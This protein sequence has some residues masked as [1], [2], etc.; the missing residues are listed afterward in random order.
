MRSFAG[1]A[2]QRSGRTPRDLGRLRKEGRQ[3][4]IN[5]CMCEGVTDGAPESRKGTTYGSQC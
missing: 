2:E 1:I 4:K 3:M 5:R